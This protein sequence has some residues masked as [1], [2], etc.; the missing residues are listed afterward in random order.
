MAGNKD[1][2]STLRDILSINSEVR[3]FSISKFQSL[4][5][6]HIDDN[7][8]SRLVPYEK[9]SAVT[10]TADLENWQMQ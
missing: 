1:S 2:F 6:A 9:G 3:G 8:A 7:L 10:R 4:G 5:E